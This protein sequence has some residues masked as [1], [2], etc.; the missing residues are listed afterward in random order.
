[1]KN[2]TLLITIAL[3]IT[4]TNLFAQLMD[5]DGNSYKTVQ[6]G[7]QLWMAT[8]LHVSHFRNGDPIPEVEDTVA[9][10]QADSAHTPAWCFYNTSAVN[11][12]YG[13]L[14]NWY[15]VSDPRG[16]APDGWHVP[17][18][19]DWANLTDYLGG[20]NVAGTK[21]KAAFGW[22]GNGNGTNE[23]GFTGLPGGYRYRM[24]TFYYV[25]QYGDWWSSSED[26]IYGAWCRFM[27]GNNNGIYRY[28]G[29]KG[30][31]FSVRCVRN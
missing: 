21:M 1:M 4:T 5:K 10:Q 18:N 25:G 20:E 7:K 6:I 8:N 9:W 31:G 13:K 30:C 2:K 26:D 12:V 19:L 17:S 3:L 16:I 15:A 14:Y 22:P 29:C 27:N 24:G 11:G 23:S 28:D